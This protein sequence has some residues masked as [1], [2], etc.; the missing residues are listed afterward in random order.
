[1]D[2]ALAVGFAQ[3]PGHLLHECRDLFGR[4]W[5]TLDPLPERLSFDILHRDEGQAF[6]LCHLVNDADIRVGEGRSGLCLDEEARSEFVQCSQVRRQELEGHPA[7]EL[8]VT[9]FV[10]DAHPPAAELPGNLVLPAD[11]AI[12]RREIGCVV[13]WLI[14]GKIT[15]VFN[16]ALV[17][18]MLA[19]ER[20]RALATIL[21]I[22]RVLGMAARTFHEASIL[23]RT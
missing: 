8:R 14:R 11:Q 4:Q 17:T 10:D 9:G 12:G 1:M 3:P 19:M 2:D 18:G 16:Q 15:L 7:L 22:G 6:I 20:C 13:E 5:L 21:R 23:D